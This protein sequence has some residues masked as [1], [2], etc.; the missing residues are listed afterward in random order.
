M[1]GDID[2][3]D[4]INKYDVIFLSE[5]WISSKYVDNLELQNL[6]SYHIYGQTTRGVKKGHYSEALVC[7]IEAFIKTKFQ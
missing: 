6:E 5:T 2:F 7:I 4:H 3:V 1:L